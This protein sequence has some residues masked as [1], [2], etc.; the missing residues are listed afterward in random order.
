MAKKHNKTYKVNVKLIESSDRDGD[1]VCFDRTFY[2]TGL[3]VK[4]VI[5][6][7]RYNNHWYDNDS[8]D[9]SAQYKYVFTVEEDEHNKKEDKPEQLNLFDFD[10]S[11]EY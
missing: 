11:N 8:Y 5:H 4:Q 7:L 3:S 2:R 1:I 6:R 9:G 10:F